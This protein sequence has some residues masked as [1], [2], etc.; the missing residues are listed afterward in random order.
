MV[1]GDG[2]VEV[3][4]ERKDKGKGEGDERLMARRILRLA[5]KMRAKVRAVV[6][7]HDEGRQWAHLKLLRTGAFFSAKRLMP[8]HAY[9]CR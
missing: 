7:S 4:G 1:D 9:T 5:R 6:S 3:E 8:T 2:E